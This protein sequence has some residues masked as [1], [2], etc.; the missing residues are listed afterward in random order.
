MTDQPQPMSS[1]L[2]LAAASFLTQALEINEDPSTIVPELAPLKE[3][4]NAAIYSVELDSSIGS[5]AFL[6]YVYALQES[7]TEGRTGADL[8]QAGLTTL[9]QAAE[10]DTPGPRLVAHAD[11]E[12][13]GFILA[14]TPTTWRRLQGEEPALFATEADLPQTEMSAEQRASVAEDLH[15]TLKEANDHARSW[16]A[17]I[18]SAGA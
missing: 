7:D 9:H 8:Y 18:R 5:A 15:R 3:N 1:P 16:L 17:G 6:V 10:R 11:T 2:A 12:T 4:A 14:T 13:A